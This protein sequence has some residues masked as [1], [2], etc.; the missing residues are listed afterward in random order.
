MRVENLCT[1]PEKMVWYVIQDFEVE[2]SKHQF[3]KVQ[4]YYL[5]HWSHKMTGFINKR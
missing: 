5:L 2:F 1:D 3:Q 4:T